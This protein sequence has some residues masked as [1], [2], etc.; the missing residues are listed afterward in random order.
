MGFKDMRE[1]MAKLEADGELMRITAE[2]DWNL[3]LGAVAQRALAGRGPALLF[4]NIKDY[5]NTRCR[6]VLVNGLT[7]RS[8]VAMMLGLAKDAAWQEMQAVIRKRFKEPIEPVSV[9]TGPV[10]ENVVRGEDIDLYQ[11]PVP[12]WHPLDGGRYIDTW[13]GIITR[14]PDTGVMNVGLYRGMIRA[15]NKI[16]KL[17]VP[18]Q[19][20]G[21]HYQKY[22]RR[23]EAMPIA[24]AYG[25][26]D[27]MPFVAS[28]P[29]AHPPS[30][31]EVIGAIR[32]EPVELVRCETSDLEVPASAEIVV[33]G[34][35]SPEPSDYEDEGPFGEW[36]G[37]YGWT[38]KRPVVQVE[39]ITHRNDPI[40]RGQ[41]EGSKPGIISEG[42][43]AGLYTYTS[44]VW[45][46]LEKAG[47]P[48]VLDIVSAPI[49]VVKIRKM[50]AGHAKQVAA[51]IF[52]SALTLQFAKVVIVVDEDVDIHNF[53]ELQLAI[54]D[55]VDAKD[56]VIVFPGF[57]GN[58][59]DPSLPWD[60]R[61]ELKYGASPHNKLLIDATID[62]TKH[63]VREEWGNR[64]Y[65]PLS[66]E[67]SSEIEQLVDSRW[68]EYGF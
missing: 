50:Y 28:I 66:T 12:K 1:W 58:P 3:E 25:W 41:V 20:W 14:D 30:E 9:A 68:K 60:F 67:T 39:C 2:V 38:R 59:L 31:Y 44:L 29:L 17:L 13:C 54:R 43:Y 56:D 51:A 27:A 63:P 47:V 10:K 35:I 61:D 49:T 45:D 15:R 40:L 5:Q 19:H 42:G 37:Y 21:L 62:W 26:D 32:Q 7:K 52:G 16:G 22:Q 65:P 55:R 4:E 46:Y 64:R 24:I 18:S 34:F 36:T 48:G 57:P 8:R 11:F 33:E 6:K 53:R 23:K